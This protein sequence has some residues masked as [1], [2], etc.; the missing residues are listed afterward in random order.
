M[1][2]TI[3]MFLF[4]HIDKDKIESICDILS[5]TL[6]IIYLQEHRKETRMSELITLSI[7]FLGTSLGAAMVF[8]LKDK[9]APRIEKLLLGFAAGVMIAASVR[10]EERRVGKECRSRWSPYH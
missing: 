2:L 10:S 9:I 7:P 5:E 1:R 8:F 4:L 3:A 6:Q